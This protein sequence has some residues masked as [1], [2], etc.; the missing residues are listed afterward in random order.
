DLVEFATVGDGRHL[1]FRVRQN[2]RDAGSAIAFGLGAQLDR[3]RRPGRYDVAFRLD[4]NRWNGTVSPQ[5]VVRRIFDTP[6]GYEAERARRIRRGRHGR[7]T[8]A[9]SSRATRRR[10]RSRA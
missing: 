4:A 2:G 6:E 1:R 5:L 10:A 3:L 7:A 8:T 9:A